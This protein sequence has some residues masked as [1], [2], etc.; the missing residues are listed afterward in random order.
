MLFKNKKLLTTLRLAVS[1][2]FVSCSSQRQIG[3]TAHE[4][5]IEKGNL[6]NSHIGISIFDPTAKKYLYNYQA[7]KY[8]VPASNTKIF[9]CYAAM[10]FLGDSLPGIRYLEDDTA[11]YLVPTGDPSL[12]HIDFPRHPVAN[13]LRAA[14][15]SLYITERFWKTQALGSGWAWNDF[16]ES[17]MAERSALPV[18]GNLITWVQERTSDPNPDTMAFDQSVSIYSLPEVDWKVRFNTDLTKKA[19]YVQ[20]QKEQNIFQVTEGTETKKEQRVPFVTDGLHSAVTLLADTIFHEIGIAD[21]PANTTDARQIPGLRVIRSQPTDSV[22]APMMHRSDNF[23]ADQVL[24]MVSNE[25]LGV[26]DDDS[27]ITHLLNT[28]L[29]D[30]PQRPRWVDGS[31]LSRY[32]VFTPH[33][34]VAI[35][36]KIQSEFSM[37]RIKSIFPT[38]GEGTLSAYPKAD[39]GYI[40]AKTGTLSG[41]VGL[42]GYLTTR[43]DRVLIFSILV[44]N[45]RMNATEVRRNV[46]AFLTD[47]RNRY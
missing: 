46:Q 22:L 5:L 9:S 20:R 6:A 41:V 15:K 36:R 43:K 1:V 27:V 37:E 19:F 47:V 18:Y 21:L 34:F 32:N 24:L 25:L 11:I 10:K 42:S 13:F 14:K 30:L 31:G 4:L 28:T 23:F 45:H 44:N 39:S 12:L 26:M 8:F 17:Y 29:A 2:I 40:F 35:L 3:K 7:E 38:A 33:S 16:N